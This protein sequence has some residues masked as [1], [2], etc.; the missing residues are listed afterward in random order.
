MADKVHD[1]GG[2]PFLSKSNKRNL[3]NS[4]TLPEVDDKKSKIFVS[5]NRYAALC[6]NDSNDNVFNIPTNS[7][8]VHNEKSGS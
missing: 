8:A 4:S 6:S 3:S 7:A 2:V 5:P 1:T